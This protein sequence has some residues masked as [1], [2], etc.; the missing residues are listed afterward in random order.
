[1]AMQLAN[2]QTAN[3]RELQRRQPFNGHIKTAEQRTIRQYGDWYTGR[4][5]VGC[6]I[7]YSEEAPGRA[8]PRS[9][10]TVPNVTAHPSIASVPSSYDSTW[11]YNCLCAIKGQLDSCNIGAKTDVDA[12]TEFSVRPVHETA[13]MIDVVHDARWQQWEVERMFWRF[14]VQTVA[15]VSADQCNHTLSPTYS[16]CAVTCQFVGQK[17]KS[18]VKHNSVRKVVKLIAI[19]RCVAAGFVRHSMPPPASNVTGTALGQ[20]GSNWSR[21][22][23]T[24]T[25]DLGGH[26]TG[27]RLPSVDQVWSS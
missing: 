11:H 7:W 25:F 13:L 3:S 24:L 12:F 26:D 2:K 9:L 17:L 18:I 4:W 27:R 16:G 22:L 23:A 10:L 1:M 19:T 6:Y 5:W 14:V 8:A 15:P 20:D 21:D